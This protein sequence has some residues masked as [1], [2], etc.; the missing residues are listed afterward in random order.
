MRLV[1]DHQGR[2][3]VVI[4]LPDWAARLQAGILQH[5]PGRPFTPDNYL[6]LQTDSICSHNGL[7]DLG[8][9]PTP[10]RPLLDEVLSRP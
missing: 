6:S 1:A 8:I 10:M 3:K 2:H 5:M 9:A 7:S 4:R